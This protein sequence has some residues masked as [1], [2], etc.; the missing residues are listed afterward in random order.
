MTGS[1]SLGASVGADI[2]RACFVRRDHGKRGASRRTRS[3]PAS[4]NAAA[5]GLLR[6]LCASGQPIQMLLAAALAEPLLPASG[7]ARVAAG[8]DGLP[9]MAP[10]RVCPHPEN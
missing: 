9:G 1:R 8:F 7:C 3:A 5:A 4:T 10:L 2:D 6:P